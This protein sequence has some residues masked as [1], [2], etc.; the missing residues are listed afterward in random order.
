MAVAQIGAQAARPAANLVRVESKIRQAAAAGAALVVFPECA[1]TGYM[2]G[3]REEAEAA[4]L[5][6]DGPE[7]AALTALC[8]EL[9]V[10]A[11]AGLLERD[12]GM[13]YNTAL[14]IGPD[15]VAGRHRKRHLPH[16]G[17]DRFTDEPE[18]GGPSVFETPFGAVG[19][20]ICYEVRF[21]EVARTLALAGADVIA[22][23]TNWPV[24]SRNLAEQFTA[25]RAAENLVYL[26]AANRPDREGDADFV[27]LS[28]IVD[29][30]GR[31]LVTAGEDGEDLLVADIDVERARDKSIVF[32]EDTFV[33]R[34]FADR[35]PETYAL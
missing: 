8:A 14:L 16:L 27:G 9:G 10:H 18:P 6:A 17:A 25:V 5:R 30:S 1:L 20:E 3:S 22:V 34:P 31:V 32:E 29:P 11:V 23:P 13:L 26:L 19:I 35:R 2:L 28:R 4:A 12:G 24:Q 7:V 21:P 15:G 33:V